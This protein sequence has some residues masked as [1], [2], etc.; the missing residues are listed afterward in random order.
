MG[1]DSLNFIFVYYSN[2]S[3]HNTFCLRAYFFVLNEIFLSR[4]LLLVDYAI[5]LVSEPFQRNMLALNAN[6]IIVVCVLIMK[7]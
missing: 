5:Q 2:Q 6:N 4:K 3:K 1:R 7:S